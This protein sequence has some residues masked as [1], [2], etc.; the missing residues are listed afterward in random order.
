MLSFIY[1]PSLHTTSPRPHPDFKWAIFFRSPWTHDEVLCILGYYFFVF[2][3]LGRGGDGNVGS[4]WL[5]LIAIP[6]DNA[7]ASRVENR[8]VE[9]VIVKSVS[10]IY[11][12]VCRSYESEHTR[13]EFFFFLWNQP[14]WFLVHYF[15][16]AHLPI[17]II[18]LSYQ[19]DCIPILS[20]VRS[21][22]FETYRLWRCE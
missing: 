5:S 12:Y 14:R 10:E 17:S 9:T 4:A 6:R 16:E 13:C 18:V 15:H 11:V 1:F 7:I 19:I 2:I 3:F 8:F 22:T 21:D 20:G